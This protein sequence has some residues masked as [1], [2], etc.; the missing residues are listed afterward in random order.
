MTSYTTAQSSPGYEGLYHN[1]ADLSVAETAARL[2][3]LERDN[4][5]LLALIREVD[6]ADPARAEW[7][8][9]HAREQAHP[10]RELMAR[11]L[12]E[13][14]ALRLQ[15]DA[16]HEHVGALVAK[17]EAMHGELDHVAS[18]LATEIGAM[19]C[20]QGNFDGGSVANCEHCQAIGWM[21]RIDALTAD[22]EAALGLA[23]AWLR[24]EGSHE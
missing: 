12:E 10:G 3:E 5:G 14:T 1:G 11:T 8:L 18:Y 21:N 7:L 4:A 13:I 20:T 16:A 9:A 6:Y 22:S 17:S 15:L 19:G 2:N 23:R 24:R